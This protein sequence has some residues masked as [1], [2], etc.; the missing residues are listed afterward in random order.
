[1]ASGLGIP[2]RLSG[3]SPFRSPGL[4]DDIIHLRYERALA[5]TQALREAAENQSHSTPEGEEAIQRAAPEGPRAR[6]NE[7]RNGHEEEERA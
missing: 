4:E 5:T 6:V 1:M 7:K 3:A 2:L